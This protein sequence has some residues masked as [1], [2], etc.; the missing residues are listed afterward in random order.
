MK[1]IEAQSDE[2]LK[3]LPRDAEY[4]CY[5]EHELWRKR[6]RHEVRYTSIPERVALV[7]GEL[8][9]MCDADLEH[10]ADEA[11]LSSEERDIWQ[12][13]V[14]GGTIRKIANDLGLKRTTAYRR[15]LR[16][17]VKVSAVAARHPYYGWYIAYLEDVLRRHLF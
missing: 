13:A 8:H 4:P 2:L 14:W 3:A 7:N 5:T 1:T 17:R 10:F 12:E 15:L 11:G 16:V 9:E 6:V